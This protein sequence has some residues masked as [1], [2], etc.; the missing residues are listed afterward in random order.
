MKECCRC[1]LIGDG[2][3]SMEMDGQRQTHKL[4]VDNLEPILLV[5]AAVDRVIDSKSLLYSEK[6]CIISTVEEFLTIFSY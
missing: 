6:S 4:P 3:L 5:L 2:E 1:A